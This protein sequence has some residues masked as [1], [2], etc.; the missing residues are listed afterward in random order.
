[1]KITPTRWCVHEEGEPVFAEH[2]THVEIDDE[3]AGP[4]I[5]IQQHRDDAEKG[6]VR[7]NAEEWPS[8]VRAVEM[9]IEASK[10]LEDT[11]P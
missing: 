9:A 4:F 5:V 3:A 6:Q 10:D 1:M 8:I 11:K 2:N 7:I